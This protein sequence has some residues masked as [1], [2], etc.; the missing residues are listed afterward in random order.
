MLFF[1][2]LDFNCSNPIPAALHVLLHSLVLL[3]GKLHQ[4]GLNEAFLLE[5]SLV[6]AGLEMVKNQKHFSH[7]YQLLFQKQ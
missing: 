6:V 3:V 5:Q 2:R 4:G 7:L 1:I